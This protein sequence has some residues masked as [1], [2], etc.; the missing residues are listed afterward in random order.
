MQ[1]AYDGD[2]FNRIQSLIGLS[3]DLI[4][5]SILLD[6]AYVLCDQSFPSHLEG[7]EYACWE[8]VSTSYTHYNYASMVFYLSRVPHSFKLAIMEITDFFLFQAIDPLNITILCTILLIHQ[9]RILFIVMTS[10]FSARNFCCSG[11]L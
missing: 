4:C 7:L 6:I 8:Y 3:D 5:S 11:E 1:R 10:T 2:L 9:P